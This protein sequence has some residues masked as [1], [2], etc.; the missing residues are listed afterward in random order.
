MQY[1]P[2]TCTVF[3]DQLCIKELFR[4]LSTKDKLIA[5]HPGLKNYNKEIWSLEYERMDTFIK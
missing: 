2:H 1:F 4:W 3:R 5:F